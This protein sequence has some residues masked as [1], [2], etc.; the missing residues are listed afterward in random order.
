M[1]KFKIFDMKY[2]EYLRIDSN[3]PLWTVNKEDATVFNASDE[4]A[5]YDFCKN[6]PRPGRLINM[7]KIPDYQAKVEVRKT[8]TPGKYCIINLN[9]NRYLCMKDRNFPERGWTDVEQL[10][11]LFYKDDAI[12]TAYKINK[13]TAYN[14]FEKSDESLDD[15]EET[16]TTNEESS[17]ANTVDYSNLQ[18]GDH[19]KDWV[20]WTVLSRFKDRIYLMSDRTFLQSDAIGLIARNSKYETMPNY[21]EKLLDDL[22]YNIATPDLYSRIKSIKMP[23]ASDANE[24]FLNNDISETEESESNEKFLVWLDDEYKVIAMRLDTRK[25]SPNDITSVG[26]RLVV[27]L[28]F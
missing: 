5:A 14:P 7:I 2:E 11:E 8:T 28:G 27:E 10:A 26:I 22:L 15:K 12:E 3:I 19:L 16:E 9:T 4:D 17:S 20:S 24:W 21:W 23:K 13:A 1:T 18:P 25:C 6:D